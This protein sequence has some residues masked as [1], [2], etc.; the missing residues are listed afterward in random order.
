MGHV[1]TGM[2]AAYRERIGDDRLRHVVEHVRVW[3]FGKIEEKP[4][5]K[6][7]SVISDPID[8]AQKN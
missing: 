6:L 5:T 2:A 1:A 8:P 7:N 3:L 4:V